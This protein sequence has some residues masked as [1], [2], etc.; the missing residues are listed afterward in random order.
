MRSILLG[1][2]SMLIFSCDQTRREAGKLSFTV[3]IDKWE[4]I[5]ELDVL[6]VKTTLLNTTS[7]TITYISLSCT[8]DNAYTIDYKDLIIF[9]SICNS[10]NNEPMLI[11]LPPGREDTRVLRLTSQKRIDQLRNMKFRIGFNLVTAKDHDN[12][13][14]KASELR[15]MKNVIWS[16]VLEIK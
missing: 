3:N 2:I 4:K 14:D 8:W 13:G 5:G 12:L 7:D 16:D 6:N 10:N 9:P 1:F 11:K 15:Q